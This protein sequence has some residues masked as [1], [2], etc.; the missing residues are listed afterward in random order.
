MTL[1]PS[2]NGLSHS[3]SSAAQSDKAVLRTPTEKAV[4]LRCIH[5]QDEAF[6]PRALLSV[7]NVCSVTLSV[8]DMHVLWARLHD[9][10]TS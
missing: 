8:A 1:I 10:P 5:K 9:C 3:C 6:S 2:T 4:Q 7:L